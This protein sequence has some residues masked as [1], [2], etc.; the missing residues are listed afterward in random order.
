MA[1]QEP[2]STTIYT[3]MAAIAG[4][5]TALAF[6]KWQEMTAG[7]IMFALF[8][9]ASFAWFVTP[10]ILHGLTGETGPNVRYV[11]GITYIMASGSNALLPLIISKARGLLVRVFGEGDIK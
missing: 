5:I 8:V 1:P 10:M 2:W 3:A 9:G 6:R 11:S 7:E 4:A